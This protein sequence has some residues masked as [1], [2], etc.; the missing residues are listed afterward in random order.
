MRIVLITTENERAVC[1]IKPKDMIEF[2]GCTFA[3]ILDNLAEVES[4]DVIPC[5]S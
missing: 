2:D 1:T 5:V 3:D 4:D